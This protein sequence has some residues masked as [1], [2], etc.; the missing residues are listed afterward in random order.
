MNNADAFELWF[1]NELMPV[2]LARAAPAAV[3][4]LVTLTSNGLVVVLLRVL[5]R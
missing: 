1:L 5:C 3:A 4:D 2:L